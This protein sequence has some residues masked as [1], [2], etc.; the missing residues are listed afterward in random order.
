MQVQITA[1]RDLKLTEGLSQHVNDKFK[2][3]E[4]HFSHITDIH[5]TLSVDKKFQQMAKANVHLAGGGTVVAD[6]TSID[7]YASIDMLVD[8]VD[9]QIKKH[10]EKLQNRTDDISNLLQHGHEE[11]P[12][13]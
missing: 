11:T 9:K 4:K 6:C 3:I 10:K 13:D 8:K 7:M 5:V 12:L 2:R 1:L